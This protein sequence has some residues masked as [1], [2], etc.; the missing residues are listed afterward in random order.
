MQHFDIDL[1]RV[2]L[3]VCQFQ[4]FSKAGNYLY[5]DQ[6]TVSKKVGQLEQAFHQQLFRRS[7]HGV[8]LTPAGQVFRQKAQRVLNDFAKLTGPVKTDLTDLRLGMLD[9]ISA[10]HFAQSLSHLISQLKRVV[11]DNQA[12]DL[13]AQFNDGALDAIVVNHQSAQKISGDFYEKSLFAESF[14]VLAS[15][16]LPAD[17]LSMADLSHRKILLAPRYCPVS[18][19]LNRRLPKTAQTYQV[20]YT[21]TLLE[22]V[23]C[24]D[25]ITILPWP[26]VQHLQ[27]N[28]HRFVASHLAGFESR[29]VALISREINVQNALIKAL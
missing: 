9:N 26:M 7:T 28:D 22:M 3:A 15:Q 12:Q 6:S 29:K 25:F 27:E 16:S 14:G 23:A 19:E 24:S 10:Y 20:A 11:I 17:P 21:D 2:F 18:R 1:L 4:N 8:S 13:V 5:L